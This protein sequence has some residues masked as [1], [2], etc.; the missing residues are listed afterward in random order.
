MLTWLAYLTASVV[1]GSTFLAIA[2]AIESFTPFGLSA[3]RFLPAGLL[4]LLIGRIRRERPPSLQDLPHLAV[5]GVLLLTVCMALIAWAEGRVSSGV[6]A[7]LAATVP[8]FL[9]LMEPRG[10]DLKSWVGLGVG[11][12]GVMLLLWPTR[13]SPHLVGSALL[14]IS[15]SIWSFG[16]LYGRKHVLQ[17]G[18][19]NQVGIEMLA[20]G[21]L[22]L[23][24]TP[25]VGGFTHAPLSLRSL[26][27][28]SFLIVFGSILAYSAYIFLSKAWPPAK[29]GTYAYWNPVVAVLLGCGIRGETFHA[30]MAPGLL[31]ILLGVS[32]V[33]IPWEWIRKSVTRLL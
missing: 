27:A 6:A 26:L 29:A 8:L 18:H 15:A 28:L 24:I 32:L 19:F 23:L 5:V 10:Q 17:A 1:W 7:V 13:Q 9:G 22:S 30:R 16:T 33:Q 4:A 12:L 11:F 3:A 21:L 20:A 25:F 2:Y 14:V 31:L